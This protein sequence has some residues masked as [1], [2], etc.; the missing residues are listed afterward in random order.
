MVFD[1]ASR[2]DA[3][4]DPCPG[5]QIKNQ[6]TVIQAG[7]SVSDGFKTPGDGGMYA[8]ICATDYLLSDG[9]ASELDD[10]CETVVTTQQQ[11]STP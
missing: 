2:S 7:S 9:L 6:N 4:T 8:Q 5:L 11:C 3:A 1:I 10:K